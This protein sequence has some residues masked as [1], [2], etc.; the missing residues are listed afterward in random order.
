MHDI[1]G[2]I[3]RLSISEVTPVFAVIELMQMCIFDGFRITVGNF[4]N[5]YFVISL[6]WI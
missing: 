3:A 1:D 5:R 6:C 2:L 4:I